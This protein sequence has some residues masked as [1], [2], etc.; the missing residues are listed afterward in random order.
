MHQWSHGRM[1][2]HT[3]ALGAGVHSWAWTWFAALIFALVP[4]ATG[5]LHGTE[6]VEKYVAEA[7]PPTD[8]Q[9]AGIRAAMQD[10]SPQVRAEAAY[11]CGA[12]YWSRRCLKMADLMPLLQDPDPEVRITAMMGLRG[13]G[14][15]LTPEAGRLLTAMIVQQE[16]LDLSWTDL[17]WKAI[18]AL[19]GLGPQ[20]APMVLPHVLPLLDKADA[21]MKRRIIHCVLETGRAAAPYAT[22]LLPLLNETD[23]EMRE[24]VLRAL[25][26]MD[27]GQARP[28]NAAEV[29]PA[30]ARALLPLL[31]DPDLGYS[32]PSLLGTLGP[33]AASITLPILLPM[34]D[35]PAEDSTFFAQLGKA[36]PEVVLFH[37]LPRL[38]HTEAHMRRG[39]L[40]TLSCMGPAAAPC[41]P[42]VRP[43][44]RDPDSI[45]RDLAISVLA[46]HSE[47][48]ATYF[49]DIFPL[50]QDA[51]T[52]VQCAAIDALSK[53]GSDHA[54]A[55]VR[56][57]LPL[58]NPADGDLRRSVRSAFV[59]LR[60]AA[61]TLSSEL[62]PA[63]EKA[64][65]WMQLPIIEA[66]C[67]I[68]TDAQAAP[69]I[70]ILRPY[71]QE[72]EADLRHAAARVLAGIGTSPQTAVFIREELLPLL[73]DQD[74]EMR[75]A[76]LRGLP[77]SFLAGHIQPLLHSIDSNVWHE[78]LCALM[79]MEE[80]AAPYAAEL[81]PLVQDPRSPRSLYEPV[82]EVFKTMGAAAAP[83]LHP[84]MLQRLS[85]PDREDRYLIGE[86]L[87]EL[88]NL[89][90]SPAWQCAALAAA[91]S[92]AA[93]KGTPGS[94]AHDLEQLRVHLYLWS[95]RD[96][97]LLLSVRWLGKPATAPMP[98]NGAALSAA[99]QQAVL[100]MLHTLWPHSAPYPALRQEMAAR[101]ADVAQSITTATEEKTAALL[102]S[103]D[104]QLKADT[105]KKNQPASAKARAAVEGALVRVRE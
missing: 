23:L 84:A 8:W 94:D 13:M 96:P 33:E 15:L 85:Q 82:Y 95:G 57:L 54:P 7:T 80:K 26:D 70:R 36:A 92:M 9:Q 65:P 10:P 47:G 93:A 98:A 5:T 39:I 38:R 64:N 35:D 87:D 24:L 20:V 52:R 28:P 103:I 72:K 76:V 30:V 3:T 89:H 42:D 75:A 66:L 32:I 48:S 50:L 99:E 74:L 37:L 104:E 49:K 11:Y 91:H 16:N 19:D 88:G 43:L 27:I 100:H 40:L 67:P 81:L 1:S 101:I 41:L 22:A 79:R 58:L 44:L 105:V 63:L 34:L 21:E 18:L 4:G 77:A 86:C 17:S 46:E 73:Q 45:V 59:P 2:F 97:E 61:L 68:P 90:S 6:M 56:A 14:P 55:V 69:F 71:L 51:D 29:A 31:K 83:V 25:Q 78:A 102:K 12:R 62:A 53:M 60:Q